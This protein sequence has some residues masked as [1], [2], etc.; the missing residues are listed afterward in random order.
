MTS[1]C[2]HVCVSKFT[3]T[4]YANAMIS[5]LLPKRDAARRRAYK[6]ACGVCYVA[7]LSRKPCCDRAV[8]FWNLIVQLYMTR[9][10]LYA[11]S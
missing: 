8:L 4:Q 10:T 6:S 3:G 9:F 7:C 5:H 1:H 2:A 11:L